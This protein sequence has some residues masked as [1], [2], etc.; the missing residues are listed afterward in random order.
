MT[1]ALQETISRKRY[2]V[3]PGQVLP[4][5]IER[6]DHEQPP[7]SGELSNITVSGARILSQAP[8]RFGEKFILHLASESA[9]ISIAICCEVQW[10]RQV[11]TGDEWIIGCLFESRLELD[12]LEEFVSSGLLERR[13]SDRRDISLPATIEFEL[14]GEQTE[15]D[16]NNIGP[17]GFC[18]LSRSAGTIGSRVRV[19][20]REF[21]TAQIEGRVKWQS[22]ND[23]EYRIGCQWVNRKG[24]TLARQLSTAAAAAIAENILLRLHRCDDHR[25]GGIFSWR[26]ARVLGLFGRNAFDQPV[27][28]SSRFSGMVFALVVAGL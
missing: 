4:V 7:V 14:T 18:F 11:A 6:P 24:R 9:N 13:E 27:R 26:V 19:T 17:G 3:V 8:L 21:D 20:F 5:A 15:V 25:R 22:T 2:R 1:V 28:D 23:G 16:V 12:L 10:V